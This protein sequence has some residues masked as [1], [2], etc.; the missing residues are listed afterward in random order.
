MKQLFPMGCFN[1]FGYWD[2]DLV[3][4]LNSFSMERFSF[5]VNYCRSKKVRSIEAS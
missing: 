3:S 4:M 5:Y 1:N 2:Y